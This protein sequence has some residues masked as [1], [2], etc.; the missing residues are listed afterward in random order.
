[1]CPLTLLALDIIN[2]GLLGFL[3]R[4]SVSFL[5]ISTALLFLGSTAKPGLVVALI[6]S[7]PA[8]KPLIGVISSGQRLV[9]L[10][11]VL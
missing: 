11:I 5:F 1:M 7:I 2:L 6:S 9:P 3:P 4:G 8:A 10:Y